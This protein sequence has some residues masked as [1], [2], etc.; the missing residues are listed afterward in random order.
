MW[1][2]NEAE[3]KL[4]RDFTNFTEMTDFAEYVSATSLILTY[5][6]MHLTEFIN[7]PSRVILVK[8]CQDPYSS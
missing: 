2:P 5:L 1:K 4:N 8:P 7:L 6:R 3:V